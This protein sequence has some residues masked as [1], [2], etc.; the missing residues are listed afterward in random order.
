[1]DNASN[2][3]TFVSALQRSLISR[4]IHFS[5]SKQRIRYVQYLFHIGL[6]LLFK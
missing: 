5:G 3:D 6:T 2:N 1:M 4:G